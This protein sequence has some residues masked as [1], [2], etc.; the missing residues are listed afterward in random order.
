MD[1]FSNVLEEPIQLL[2][3]DGETYYYGAV[4]DDLSAS[5]C[6]TQL[7]DTTV[8]QQ[9]KLLMFG[10]QVT[11]KRKVAWY[12]DDSYVYTYSNTKKRAI[13]WTPQIKL[14]KDYLEQVTGEKFNSC[15]LN[16]YH[17]GS[18]S[19]GWHS[20]DEPDIQKNSA[21]ASLSFGAER[22]FKFKHKNTKTVVSLRLC[23]GGL[24]LMKGATQIHWQHQL[25]V[26][27]NILEPR[28]NLTFRHVH[29]N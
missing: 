9:E 25:P 11:P 14:L 21:I 4:M 8:W 17:N 24:L 15:L 2:P 16:L 13:P 1:L 6:L 19:M 26:A 7:L 12:G 29:N 18:E 20:D 10:K 3:H 27:K 23:H 28:V 5:D 22:I